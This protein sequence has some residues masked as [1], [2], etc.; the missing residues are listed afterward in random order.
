MVKKFFFLLI[1]FH[2][3]ACSIQAQG[4][5]YFIMTLPEKYLGQIPLSQRQMLMNN[6][7]NGKKDSIIPNRFGGTSK[8]L[9][10]D[11]KK[12]YIKIQTS[13]QGTI[14]AKKIFLKDNTPLYAMSFDVCSPACDGELS[15]YKGEK[16]QYFSMDNFMPEIKVIDFFDKDSLVANGYKEED[17]EDIF[18]ALF[19]VYKID[20]DSD[21]LTLILDNEKYLGKELFGRWKPLMRGNCMRLKWNGRTYNKGE[22][23]FDEK[24]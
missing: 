17:A 19:F 9:C 10:Y 2:A 8:L 20:R 3:V 7:K 12:E 1:L 22:V 16:L 5:D 18:E 14:T 15:F 6:I 11:E 13:S 23:F 21:N 4:I 24:Q